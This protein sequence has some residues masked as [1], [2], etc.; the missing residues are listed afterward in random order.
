VADPYNEFLKD[1]KSNENFRI[2]KFLENI[3]VEIMKTGQAC[4]LLHRFKY[5]VPPTSEDLLIFQN[6]EVSLPIAIEECIAR[7]VVNQ[8]PYFTITYIS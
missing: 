5:S 1:E 6:K 7:P 4:N 3:A 8:Y 2:P